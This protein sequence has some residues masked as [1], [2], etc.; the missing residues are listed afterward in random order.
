MTS[1]RLTRETLPAGVLIGASA[2]DRTGI[3]HLGLGNF[4]RAHVAVYTAKA[5]EAEPGDWGIV[6][7]ANRSHTVVDGLRE[8]DNLYSVVQLTPDGERVGVVDVHRRTLVAADEAAEVLAAIA[9]PQHKIV[10]ITVSENGYH[11]DAR[12]GD[13][14]LTSREIRA[15][16]A[17]PE[18]PHTTIGLVAYG[19]IR[20]ASDTG[21][22]VTILS[23]DNLQSAGTA[24]RRTVEQFLRAAGAPTSVFDWIASSVTF[25]NAMV[26]RIVPSTTD[27]TRA[28]VARVLGVVDAVPVPAEEFTMWVMEDRFAAGRPRWEAAG[29]VFTDDVEAYELV[30]LRLLNGSHSLISYLGALDGRETIPAARAQAFVADAVHAAIRD[31]YL[32]SIRLPEGFDADAYVASL[33][34]R[35]SNTALGDKT[36]RV[37]S[38]GSTKLQQRIP[39]PALHLLAG[40]RMPH[41]LAL[42]VAAWIC[43]VVPPRG[44]TPGPVADAMVDSARERLAAATSGATDVRSHVEAVMNGGFF[45]DEL[46]AHHAFTARVAD[47]AQLVVDRGVRAAATEAL[48]SRAT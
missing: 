2:P 36:S 45:P 44:F 38:D 26:D 17:D 25:P 6:G 5:L 37:G 13:L 3:V 18:N 19:L 9:D 8:Q 20:R 12:T 1:A 40:G 46:A 15:D 29:A 35:W 30:K 43:C 10:T 11:R 23:C 47:L 39:G 32:P 41:Q 34:T 31:E 16:L 24:T 33:F 4:H 14:D 27:E 42:T 21:A 7:V 22:P 48:A 28:T